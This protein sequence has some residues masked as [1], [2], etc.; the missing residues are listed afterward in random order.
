[1]SVYVILV[2]YMGNGI[3]EGVSSEGYRTLDEAQHFVETRYPEPKKVNEF[4]Y[5]AKINN[6]IETYTICEISVKE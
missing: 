2:T 1:M 6:S 5:V 4:L 3:H